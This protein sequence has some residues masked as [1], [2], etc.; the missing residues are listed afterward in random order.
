MS[1]HFV[2]VNAEPWNVTPWEPNESLMPS[3]TTRLQFPAGELLIKGPPEVIPPDQDSLLE[4][5]LTLR[6]DL[7]TVLADIVHGTDSR[8]STEE[9]LFPDQISLFCKE[10]W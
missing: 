6:K 1:D 2:L 8:L 9:R 4:A 3:G 10:V 7:S 5:T